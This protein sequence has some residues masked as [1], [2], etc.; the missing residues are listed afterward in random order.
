MTQPSKTGDRPVTKFA[1]ILDNVGAEVGQG[2][3][4]SASISYVVGWQSHS[5]KPTAI[6]AVSME[7]STDNAIGGAA[8]GFVL[9]GALG[10]AVG[11][12]VGRGP[13]VTFEI[14]TDQGRT[15]RC[16]AKRDDYLVVKRRVDRMIV[17]WA[18]ISAR[19][20]ARTSGPPGSWKPVLNFGLAAGLVFLPPL[21]APFLLRKGTPTWARI[22]GG[23]WTVIWLFVAVNGGN[24]PEPPNTGPTAPTAN[25]EPAKPATAPPIEGAEPDRSDVK[26]SRTL[27]MSFEACNQWIAQTADQVGSAPVNV[28][29]SRDVRVVRFQAGDGSVLVTCSR[30]DRKAVIVESSR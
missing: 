29:D 1:V 16:I 4:G 20:A 19:Q 23:G 11:A 8:W 12:I 14:D 28:V 9:A 25:I 2:V 26:S 30:K 5:F 13:Q 18:K 24:T 6:R 15:L 17:V 10:A 7:Q 22:V 3:L 27:S 21:F